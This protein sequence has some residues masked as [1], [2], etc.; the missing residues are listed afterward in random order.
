[1]QDL[2]IA[3]VERRTGHAPENFLRSRTS[4]EFPVSLGA[5]QPGYGRPKKKEKA[6]NLARR[7]EVGCQGDWRVGGGLAT[8]N[9]RQREQEVISVKVDAALS[10]S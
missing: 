7:R 5:H 4:G 1:M 9:E 8:Q 2:I 10:P 3:Y 6:V